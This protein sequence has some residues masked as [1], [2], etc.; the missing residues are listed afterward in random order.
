MEYRKIDIYKEMRYAEGYE[1]WD[2]KGK[3]VIAEGQFGPFPFKIINLEGRHPCAYISVPQN[4]ILYAKFTD[5]AHYALKKV[6]G[7]VTFTG[8]HPDLGL[9]DEWF[10]GWDYAHAGDH[11]GGSYYDDGRKRW[12]VDE[13]VKEVEVVADELMFGGAERCLPSGEIEYVPKHRKDVILMEVP[14]NSAARG[15]L[16]DNSPVTVQTL[17]LELKEHYPFFEGHGDKPVLLL[18]INRE[19]QRY[20]GNIRLSLKEVESLAEALARAVEIAK[21]AEKRKGM[22]NEA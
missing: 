10:I 13:L 1:T 12:T 19:G 22:K 7:G 2:G 9:I 18:W 11:A 16:I 15:G 3:E 8:P 6:H 14:V 5:D 20:S 17:I 4:H 21:K